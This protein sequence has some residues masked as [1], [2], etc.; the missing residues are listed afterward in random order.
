MQKETLLS[1]IQKAAIL[2]QYARD[3]QEIDITQLTSRSRLFYRLRKKVKW[4]LSYFK[5]NYFSTFSVS[6]HL[7][8]GR[9]VISSH[10]RL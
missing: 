7:P 5:I 8:F 2:I 9:L 10:S 6:C 1:P 3:G 4:F